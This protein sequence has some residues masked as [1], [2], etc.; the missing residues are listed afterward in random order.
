[1]KKIIIDS[2]QCLAL[3]LVLV[4]RNSDMLILKL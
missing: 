3:Q 2:L 1:M 4:H